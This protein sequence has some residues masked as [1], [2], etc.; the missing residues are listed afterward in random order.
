MIM[1]GE[2]ANG[3][4]DRTEN[5]PKMLIHSGDIVR[6]PVPLS[7]LARALIDNDGPLA[8][9]VRQVSIDKP[10]ETAKVKARIKEN[11]GF[12]DKRC[13][14]GYHQYHSMACHMCTIDTK[15][16]CLKCSRHICMAVHS[17]CDCGADQ[18]PYISPRRAYA[19]MLNACITFPRYAAEGGTT[20]ISLSL[21]HI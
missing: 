7:P 18:R 9:L 20:V 1:N 11:I 21:I 16:V 13:T 6:I 3:H 12:I 19:Q 14:L 8:T 5:V 17:V 10:D 4:L 15:Y 2:N